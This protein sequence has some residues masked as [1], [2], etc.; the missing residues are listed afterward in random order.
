MS[1]IDKTTCVI[2]CIF[3][4]LIGFVIGGITGQLTGMGVREKQAIERG[5]AEYHQSTGEW[6]WKEE[7][8]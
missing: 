8:K 2:S 4:A 1:E 7:S 6:Q 5:F 3:M